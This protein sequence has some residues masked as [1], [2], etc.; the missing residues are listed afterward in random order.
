MKKYTW[1]KISLFISFAVTICA[2]LFKIMHWPYAD[3][4]FTTGTL[5]SLIYIMIAL[6]DIYQTE[7]KTIIEKLLWLLGFIFLS[8]IAGFIYYFIVIKPKYRLQ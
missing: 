3:I 2:V 8:F 7:N 1:F 4:L 6:T 5:I